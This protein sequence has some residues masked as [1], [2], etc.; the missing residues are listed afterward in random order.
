MF[1]A[2]AAR[3]SSVARLSLT[4]QSLRL[5]AAGTNVSTSTSTPAGGNQQNI[6]QKAEKVISRYPGL[7][8]RFGAQLLR[9]TLKVAPE[10]QKTIRQ[11]ARRLAE[12]LQSDYDLRM[13]V[14]SSDVA[15]LPVHPILR[16]F[17]DE[18]QTSRKTKHLSSAL[19][20]FETMYQET[21]D[22]VTVTMT[23]PSLEEVDR[24]AE[25][26]FAQELVR[27]DLTVEEVR[28]EV[29]ESLVSGRV[30]RVGDFILDFSLRPK[31]D[32]LFEHRRR[33]LDEQSLTTMR[34]LETNFQQQLKLIR[35]PTPQQMQAKFEEIRSKWAV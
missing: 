26:K 7:L 19:E 2:L 10:V 15:A 33:Q 28:F 13:H 34:E 30:V 5:L 6:L 4:R 16:Q 18:L 32:N 24:E 21:F 25:W 9:E 17:V 3:L 14:I 1:V 22:L 8:N 23:L 27:S 35:P 31:M 20:Q 11:Q 12:V 29:D